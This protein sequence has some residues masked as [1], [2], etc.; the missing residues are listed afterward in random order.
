MN[1]PTSP[2]T[3]YTHAMNTTRSISLS[4]SLLLALPSIT[5]VAESPDS[6]AYQPREN[7]RAFLEPVDGVYTGAGQDTAG[8]DGYLRALGKERAPVIY[9]TYTGLKWN[10]EGDMARLAKDL[11]D[12]EARTGAYCVA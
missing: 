1:L 8:V 11:A 12:I 7:Y 4:L 5:L 6:R 9:M 10:I 3:G 2:L